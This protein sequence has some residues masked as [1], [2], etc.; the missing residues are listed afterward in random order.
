MQKI[1]RYKALKQSKR[2][3]KY[4]CGRR[5]EDRTEEKQK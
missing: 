4:K 1:Q 2:Q 5:K 3:L